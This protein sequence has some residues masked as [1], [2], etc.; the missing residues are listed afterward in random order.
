[1]QRKLGGVAIHTTITR[2]S[3]PGRLSRGL[4]PGCAGKGLQ[5]L[6]PP[7]HSE[8]VSIPTIQ[9]PLLLWIQNKAQFLHLVGTV[10]MGIG[11]QVIFPTGALAGERGGGE[12]S[13]MISNPPG[14]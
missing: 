4:L 1:M 8:T 2:H 11:L 3:G 12:G 5:S 14:R 10:A 13:S 7:M 9:V 6:W